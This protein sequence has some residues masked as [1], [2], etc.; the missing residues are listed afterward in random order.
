[1]K[2]LASLG[3]TVRNG[4][5]TDAS[6]QRAELRVA[7]TDAFV[8]WFQT[9]KRISD[10]DQVIGINVQLVSRKELS[11]EQVAAAQEW[12]REQILTVV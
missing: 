5:S 3:L 7:S 9:N 8:A 12:L 1:M 4:N 10:S 11:E 6:E 2:D